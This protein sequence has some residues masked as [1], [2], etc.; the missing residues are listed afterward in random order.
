MKFTDIKDLKKWSDEERSL[1]LGFFR[2]NRGKEVSFPDKG[3]LSGWEKVIADYAEEKAKSSAKPEKEL[4]P[5]AKAIYDKIAKIKGITVEQLEVAKK[6]LMANATIPSGLF[7]LTKD[8]DILEYLNKKIHI[9]S[10]KGTRKNKEPK[11]EKRN[12]DYTKVKLSK[13]ERE[14][15][16]AMFKKA[17]LAG[18]TIEEVEAVI[19]NALKERVNKDKLDRIAKLKAELAKEEESL[20][21]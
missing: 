17:K 9:K 10:V 15:L 3:D 18:V 20:L 2:K 21:Y 7:K 12:T 8:A 6:S 14:T 16:V 4:S 5:D 13:S 11:E 19:S 1:L